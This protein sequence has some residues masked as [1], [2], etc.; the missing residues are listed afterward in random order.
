MF[1]C[2]F[3]LASGYE[4]IRTWFSSLFLKKPV[5]GLRVMPIRVAR[6]RRERRQRY[7]RISTHVRPECHPDVSL[8]RHPGGWDTKERWKTDSDPIGARNGSELKNR[9]IRVGLQP[10]RK[11]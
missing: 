7:T 4:V 9:L 5:A 6:S 11:L 2:A 3:A 8:V 1:V 10:T